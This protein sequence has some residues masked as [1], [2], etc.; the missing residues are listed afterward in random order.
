M[1]RILVSN[2]FL[3]SCSF[4]VDGVMFYSVQDM[5]TVYELR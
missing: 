3:F 4:C 5:V 2:S 1:Q